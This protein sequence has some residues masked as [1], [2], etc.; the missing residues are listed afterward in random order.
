MCFEAILL[1]FGLCANKSVPIGGVGM[2]VEIH[3]CKFDMHNYNSDKHV[4]VQL[5]G[6]RRCFLN[7][8][9]K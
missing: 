7:S 5:R 8:H 2:E 6:S 9:G 4:D 3:G 1:R